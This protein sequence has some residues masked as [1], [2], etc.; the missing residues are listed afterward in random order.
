MTMKEYQSLMNGRNGG[1]AGMGDDKAMVDKGRVDFEARK[2]NEEKKRAAEAEKLYNQKRFALSETETPPT[3]IPP[4]TGIPSQ[5]APVHGDDFLGADEASTRITVGAILGLGA[6]MYFHNLEWSTLFWIGGVCFVVGIV[7]ARS[8]LK[9]VIVSVVACAL[10][11]ACYFG[12]KA[13]NSSHPPAQRAAVVT[14]PIGAPSTPTYPHLRAS[15]SSIK[16]LLLKLNFRP[17]KS[18]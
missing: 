15:D 4:P 8:I 17:R 16:A 6:M 13:L 18:D 9:F 7:L 14:Q 10:I 5:N 12:F 2:A 1:H 11:A 3:F